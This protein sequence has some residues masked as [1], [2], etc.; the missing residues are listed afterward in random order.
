MT[1]YSLWRTIH[2]R[3]VANKRGLPIQ[4]RSSLFSTPDSAAK[5][6]VFPHAQLANQHRWLGWLLALLMLLAGSFGP[7]LIR[8][9]IDGGLN[10]TTL[11]MARYLFGVMLLGVALG[12][13]APAHFRIDRHG[14]LFAGLTGLSIGI[15]VLTFHWGL[16]R[17]S[18]S[19]ASM[20]VSVTPLFVLLLL[21][22]RGEK[23]TYRNTGRMALG[24]GG[25]YLLIGPGGQVDGWGVLLV[26]FAVLAYAGQ[27]VMVQWFLRDYDTWQVTVYQFTGAALVVSAFWLLQG[28]EWHNPGPVGWLFIGAMV[29]VGLTVRVAAIGAIRYIGSGQLALLLPLSAFLAVVWSML[30]LSEQFSLLQW[31]GGLLIITSALLAI[32]R[33][34]RARRFRR[35]WRSWLRL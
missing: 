18:A 5:Q 22:L 8:A 31:L 24:I 11:A 13:A 35:G 12:V 1:P 34:R 9:A 26:L 2:S 15:G 30:F 27:L 28:V 21:A 6:P 16:T 20:L 19:I 32:R 33:I 29:L 10:P 25:I 7:P 14:L 17:V 4:F 23:L 3:S